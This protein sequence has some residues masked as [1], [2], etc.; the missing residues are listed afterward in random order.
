VFTLCGGHISP[1][2]VGARDRGIA[3]VDCRDEKNAVFAADAV[4]RM[5]GRVGVAAVTAGPGVTNTLTAVKNAQM[6]QSPI[7]IFGGATATILEGRGSLQDIDQMSLVRSAVKWAA[8]VTTIAELG[9]TVDK[10]M[11]KARAGIPGPV[12]VEVPVDLLYPE[13]IVRDWYIKESGVENAK[14]L[15]QK[16]LGLYLK[17]HLYR[18]FHM[19]HVDLD[20]PLP[21]VK[22]PRDRRAQIDR[23][24]DMLKSARRPALVIGSQT[25]VNCTDPE[26][27]ARAVRALGVPT[28]LGGVAR[29]L[30]GRE[31][32]VQFRHGRGKALREADLV[33]VCGFPFDFR[34]KYGRG[35]GRDT[36]VVAANLSSFELRK[37][38]RPDV[39]VQMHAGEF[40]VELAAAV[41]DPDRP[42]VA[43]WFD[44]VRARES[45]RDREI[46]A[47]AQPKGEL[48]D[49]V[50]F[51]LRLEEK[52][53][54]DAVMVAD[55][56]DFVAT[57]A[58]IVRPRA[59]LSWLDPGVFGT[60]GVGGGF[61]VGAALVRPDTEVWIIYG[62]GSC[63]YSLSEFDTFV[64]HGLA[65]I[66]V[67]GTDASWAQIARDQVDVLGSAVG[68]EL[69]RTAYHTVAAG[70]GGVGLL[71]DDPDRIDETLDEAKRHAAAGRAVLVNVH[72]A[73]TD[74]RKGSISI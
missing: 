32:D 12:F 71:L 69:L 15:P 38:R 46:E 10:A 18:Q 66:A 74:F 1:I 9:P 8:K 16:A 23:V 70:Y 19:P 59:P 30:L 24:A 67:V 5:T 4:A 62:D 56:G 36:K 65:P 68:T 29:G 54:R 47:K 41:G 26:R 60:L 73:R 51:F 42:Q 53:A 28:W 50:H 37:N 7:L 39:A 27:I 40:L 35:F 21:D 58:Y 33:L 14:S 45:D 13:A 17:G 52:M 22:V 6:A 72:L 49:P 64:R 3:V 55:G 57:A 48:V 44:T 31:S 43:E 2:L 20:L 63:A 61:A 11:R 25:L 34:L